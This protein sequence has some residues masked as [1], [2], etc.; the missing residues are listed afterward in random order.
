M[1]LFKTMTNSHNPSTFMSFNGEQTT[2]DQRE[3]ETKYFENKDLS[4]QQVKAKAG[5]SE[6]HNYRPQTSAVTITGMNQYIS[7]AS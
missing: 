5:K 2:S 6:I 4:P 7:G 1:N 3:T